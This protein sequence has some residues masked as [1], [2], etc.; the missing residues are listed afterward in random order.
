MATRTKATPQQLAFAVAAG[1]LDGRT[2]T[3]RSAQV[4]TCPTCRARVLVGDD[5]HVAALTATVDPAAITLPAEALALASGRR[6]YTVRSLGGRHEIT[7]RNARRAGM[8]APITDPQEF[9]D[10]PG[11][12]VHAEHQCNATARQNRNARRKAAAK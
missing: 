3:G 8:P 9:I 11:Y 10:S 6:T 4:R 5:N 7:H 12:T 2:H 1:H